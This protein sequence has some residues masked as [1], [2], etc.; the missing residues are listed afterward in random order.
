MPS[1]P[2]VERARDLAGRPGMFLVTHRREAPPQLIAVAE[3]LAPPEQR[4][5]VGPIDS[6]AVRA[7]VA[8]YAGR[9]VEDAP[10]GDLLGESGGVPAA[11]HRVASHWAR[12]AAAGRLGASADRTAAGRRG[13][14]D[15]EAALI[16]DVADLELARERDAALRGRGRGGG[17]S[18]GRVADRLPVQGPGGVRGRRRRLLLRSRA[19]RSPSSSPGSSAA[20][21]SGS[22]ATPAAAS[23]RRSGRACCRPW[24]AGSCRAATAGPRR[25]CGRA[26]IRCP[27]S[28][29]PS[30]GP[31]PG[32]PCR[33]TMP[34]AALDAAL[35]G[36]ATGQ[37]LV[38]VVDQ[39]EEVF[40]ATR[41]DA[42]RSAF[43]DLLTGERAGLKVIVA[44]RA[45]HYGRCAAY[46]ALARLLGSDQ[47]LVGPLSQRRARGGRSSIPRSGSGC[48]WSPALTEALVADAGTEPG[49][50]PLLST[51]L[52]ELW[53]ARESGPPDARRRTARAA[54]SRAPSPGSPRPPTPSSTR[55]ARAVA[56]ALLLRLAGPGEGAELVRRRVSARRARRR[57]RSGRRR[58][59]GHPDGR[60]A[61]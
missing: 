33:S 53:Q 52:L 9:A 27:S 42:E 40:N 2:I 38:V 44:M 11:V 61:R 37:R 56:R 10:I 6:D 4:R 19:A 51:A 50:L 32:R 43:I 15:A 13:L 47:V 20:R 30:P 3:R 35:A 25:S 14:R 23:P 54:A 57:Q 17:R 28:C 41:D 45:D 31:C 26:S 59:P 36:L 21:S 34:P 46:P 7:I 48:G 22:S 55:T 49:V 24:P 1:A 16:G 12:T 58:G 5:T 60:P 39:F 8:L 29:A 18:G